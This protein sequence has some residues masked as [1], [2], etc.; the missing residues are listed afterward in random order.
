ML[1]KGWTPAP[2]PWGGGVGGSASSKALK[3]SSRNAGPTLM[4]DPPR[5]FQPL[6]TKRVKKAPRGSL[7]ISRIGIH[8]HHLPKKIIAGWIH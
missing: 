4:P 2:P 8:R 3:G 6:A 7:R 1:E 5:G